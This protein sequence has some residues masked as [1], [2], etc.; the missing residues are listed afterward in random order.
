VLALLLT[1]AV[2]ACG[3]GLLD[4][5]PVDSVP[6]EVA[7]T[8]EGGAQAALFGAYNGLESD[9]YYG[10]DYVMWS[11]TLTDN[12]EHTGTFEGYAD[13]DLL[14][15][16]PDMSGVMGM[17]TALYD[18]VYRVNLVIQRVPEIAGLDPTVS[19]EIMGQAY[20]LRALH[21]FNL[22]RAWGDVP[23]VLV[24]PASLEEAALVT[25]SPAASVYAQIES[26]L[27]QAETLLGGMSNDE[28]TL[29]TPGFVWALRARVALYRQNWSLA[30]TQARR[31][32]SSGDYALASSYRSMF[33][34]NGDPTAEDIF[35]VAFTATQYNDLG[36]YYQYDGRFEIGATETIYD[37]FPSG[38]AR[39]SVNFDGTRGD[40]IQ[41]VKYPTTIGGEDLHVIR[42]ADVVL[43]LAEA[44][45][46]QGGAGNL[47]EAVDHLNQIRARA[48]VPEYG[49]GTDLVSQQDVLDAVF[50]ERR[51]ELAFEGEYW[52][53]LVRT[54][55]AAAALGPDFQPHEALWPIPVEELDVAPNMTQNPGY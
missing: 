33:T 29:A 4:V 35:R 36:Y 21:Y 28:R 34:A 54:G 31:I 51:L 27:D 47:G 11:E 7:I 49:F 9:A 37:L 53:D 38:D 46:Q 18:A 10:G 22:V 25:R 44:L 45:A 30:A 14:F 6:D 41:V 8:D 17:W 24:P 26:D 40:G 52:F 48:G 39:F 2:G 12:V 15:M 5:N 43:I 50:L 1:M 16:R 32:I 3:D 42:Y 13:A 19:D 20:A 23:L 55:R